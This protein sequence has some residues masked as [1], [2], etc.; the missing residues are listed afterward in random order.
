MQ[1]KP[2]HAFLLPSLLLRVRLFA[3]KE[4]ERGLAGSWY[5]RKR[6]EEQHSALDSYITMGKNT[7]KGIQNLYAIE[8]KVLQKCIFPPPPRN[9]CGSEDGKEWEM[10]LRGR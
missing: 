8:F 4:R 2:G 5:K 7:L 3:V 9:H 1:R 10:G 6:A